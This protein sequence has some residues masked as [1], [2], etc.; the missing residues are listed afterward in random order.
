LE[1]QA[2]GVKRHW[3]PDFSA[4]SRWLHLNSRDRS[5]SEF[6]KLLRKEW[7]V[8]QN[9]KMIRHS[10]GIG[11]EYSASCFHR[12]L[13]RMF[14]SFEATATC[15]CKTS[16][17]PMD[18]ENPD[19]ELHNLGNIGFQSLCVLQDYDLVPRMIRIVENSD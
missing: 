1:I 2:L 5:A 6:K 11:F 9:Q 19:V 3:F 8:G 4:R 15:R 12:S 14:Q 10:T 17:F 13:A 7:F 18:T 16:H